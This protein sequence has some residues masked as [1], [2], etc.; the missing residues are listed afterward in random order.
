M[1]VLLPAQSVKTSWKHLLH[2]EPWRLFKVAHNVT[3]QH[4]YTKLQRHQNLRRSLGQRFAQAARSQLRVA[5]EKHIF[6]KEASA[7]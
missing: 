7:E 4:N 6:T 1:R 3:K 2:A 5:R